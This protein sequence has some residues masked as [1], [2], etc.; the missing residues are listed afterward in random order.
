MDVGSICSSWPSVVTALQSSVRIAAM[1]GTQRLSHPAP[2][3]FSPRMDTSYRALISNSG[4]SPGIK[5]S[6]YVAHF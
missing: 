1:S 5:L 2:L 4:F 6:D 3:P